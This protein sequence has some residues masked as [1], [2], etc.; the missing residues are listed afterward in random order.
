MYESSR[1]SL[2][3]NENVSCY[4]AHFWVAHETRKSV[5]MHSNCTRESC[6]RSI[7]SRFK[8]L[9]IELRTDFTS[10]SWR[11]GGYLF[12]VDVFVLTFLSVPQ[13]MLNWNICEHFH[14][15]DSRLLHREFSSDDRPFHL[16]NASSN[17]H[18]SKSKFDWHLK[19]HQESCNA[20]DAR[21]AL[22][23]SIEFHNKTR[24]KRQR[25]NWMLF[26]EVQK[27]ICRENRF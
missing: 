26:S 7:N 10:T 16:S 3:L 9:P 19:I 2:I 8:I 5:L 21:P 11:V 22:V 23:N 13:L 4:N 17:S 12:V 1:W 25:C 14:E 15:S 20:A 6:D 27:Y 24:Q 18:Y